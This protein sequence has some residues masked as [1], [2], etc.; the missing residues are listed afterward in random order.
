MSAMDARE[1]IDD[2][3]GRAVTDQPRLRDHALQPATFRVS[4]SAKDATM[5]VSTSSKVQ[6]VL[7][8]RDDSSQ[9]VA[10]QPRL[11]QIRQLWG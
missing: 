10:A 6:D 4:M 11:G 5:H 7:Q 1:V 3:R 2:A 8:K 9:R